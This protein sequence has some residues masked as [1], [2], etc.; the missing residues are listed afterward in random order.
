[1]NRNTESIVCFMI[2]LQDHYNKKLREI[3]CKI[4]YLTKLFE[5]AHKVKSS[6]EQDEKA[7]FG[8]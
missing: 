5:V 1:M 7:Y 4:R 8:V 3:D 6:P 2:G